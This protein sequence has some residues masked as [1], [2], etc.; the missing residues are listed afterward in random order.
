MKGQSRCISHREPE[1]LKTGGKVA[2]VAILEPWTN[3][4]F[5]LKNPTHSQR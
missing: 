3:S 2:G 5:A 4:A 1:Q